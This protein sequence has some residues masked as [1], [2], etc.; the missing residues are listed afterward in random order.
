MLIISS[1]RVRVSMSERKTWIKSTT[2][3]S[4]PNLSTSNSNSNSL[5]I[6]NKMVQKFKA[7]NTP[8][9]PKNTNSRWPMPYNRNSP[10]HPPRSPQ[11]I[12]TDPGA[13][14]SSAWAVS[15]LKKKKG[16][17]C[18]EIW[19]KT[20]YAVRATPYQLYQWILKTERFP[21]NILNLV[22]QNW[23]ETNKPHLSPTAPKPSSVGLQNSHDDNAR[24]PQIWIIY[25][26]Q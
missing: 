15:L 20:L 12:A 7:A 6:P 16:S 4:S 8:S 5:S 13:G 11:E 22:D 24:Q 1:V 17:P 26:A 3:K 2:M 18:F 23:E 25:Q 10:R 14:P 9:R 21:G 19:Y